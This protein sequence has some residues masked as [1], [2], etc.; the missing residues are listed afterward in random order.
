MKRIPVDLTETWWS[1]IS[2]SRA[3][4]KGKSVEKMTFRASTTGAREEVVELFT[5]PALLEGKIDAVSTDCKWDPGKAKTLFEMLI[6]NDFKEKLKKLGNIN[7]IV[8]TYSAGFP[9]EL[10]QPGLL[11]SKP[12]CVSTGMI[13][14]LSTPD[15]RRSIKTVPKNRALV[16]ADPDL[17]GFAGQLKG[18]SAKREN[19]STG[20]SRITWKP[21]K[22]SA[23]MIPKSPENCLWMTTKSFILPA[24]EFST[25]IRQKDQEW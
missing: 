7:W 2:V 25:G 21:Q 23:K 1:R 14:Q 15:F 17:K 4:E 24:M 9:W 22:V 13:R 16:V 10:L 18:V 20:C 3:V 5:S 6:P 11:D 8:D 12:L 19:W